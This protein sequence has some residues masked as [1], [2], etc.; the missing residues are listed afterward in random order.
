MFQC[1]NCFF[2]EVLGEGLVH[3]DGK[4]FQYSEHERICGKS[5][6]EGGALK[7]QCS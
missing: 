2:V 6:Q 1:V 7:N 5:G 3:Q 4:F